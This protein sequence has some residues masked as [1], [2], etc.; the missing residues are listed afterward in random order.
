MILGCGAGA[1]QLCGGCKELAQMQTPFCHLCEACARPCHICT[2]VT[3][4]PW[5]A[6][7]GTIRATSG[8]RQAGVTVGLLPLSSTSCLSPLFHTPQSCKVIC[9]IT[10]MTCHRV[11]CDVSVSHKPDADHLHPWK[12]H[13]CTLPRHPPPQPQPSAQPSAAVQDNGQYW[14]DTCQ[15]KPQD[16]SNTGQISSAIVKWEH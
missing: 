6:Q 14:P 15:M 13:R 3:L 5:Y 7:S 11:R 8:V 4:H 1:E 2:G 12:L 10:A 9:E 16:W